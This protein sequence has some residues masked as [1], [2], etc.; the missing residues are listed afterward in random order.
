MLYLD[1]L[2]TIPLQLSLP[3]LP[4]GSRFKCYFST[5]FGVAG[6]IHDHERLYSLLFEQKIDPTLV[7]VFPDDLSKL[8][9]CPEGTLFQRQVWQAL[10]LLGQGPKTISYQDI[11]C[12]LHMPQGSRAVGQAVGRNPINYLIPC[13]KVIRKDG[14]LGGFAW[15]PELKKKMLAYDQAF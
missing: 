6:M 5:P 7:S 14:S 1:S 4:K 12:A 8:R 2:K 15:G 9:L 10:V 13:H 3:R 11:A